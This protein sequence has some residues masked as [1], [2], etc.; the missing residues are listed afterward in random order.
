ML[1]QRGHTAH[2]V[3]SIAFETAGG[4]FGV[5]ERL[6]PY[7][8][9]SPTLPNWISWICASE[10]TG[11]AP[12]WGKRPRSGN[13]IQWRPLPIPLSKP[14]FYP[15]PLPE[16]TVLTSSGGRSSR[17]NAGGTAQAFQLVLPTHTVLQ[18]CFMTRLQQRANTE[19]TALACG[20]NRIA[21]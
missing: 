13:R 15:P 17:F 7:L 18:M 10:I 2:I 1:V 12:C 3:S 14:P 5:K 11:K 4:L 16:G 8:I 9:S 6:F 21:L 19:A 20:T